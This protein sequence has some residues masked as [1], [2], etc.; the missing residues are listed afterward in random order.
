MSLPE[1]IKSTVLPEYMPRGVLGA[2]LNGTY[3][4]YR[5]G[6][7]ARVRWPPWALLRMTGTETARRVKPRPTFRKNCGAQRFSASRR[8]RNEKR[9][10]GN[11][12]GLH[13]FHECAFSA[14]IQLSGWNDA[15]R[16]L[17]FDGEISLMLTCSTDKLYSFLTFA[18]DLD[19][20]AG[21]EPSITVREIWSGYADEKRVLARTGS[22]L[23]QAF[24]VYL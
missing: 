24:T 20:A 14:G 1:A 21:D 3:G 12:R 9:V 19:V 10:P 15:S 16:N 18:V 4:F 13:P 23:S 11:F 5:T 8:D 22:A 7:V 6:T 17:P 2:T